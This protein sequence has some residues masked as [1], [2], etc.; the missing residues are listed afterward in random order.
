MKRLM[1]DDAHVPRY[2]TLVLGGGAALPPGPRPGYSHAQM[3]SPTSLPE[4]ARAGGRVLLA[5]LLALLCV[6]PSSFAREAKEG[7]VVVLLYPEARLL[8]EILAV[9]DAIRPTLDPAGAVHLYTEYLD[10]SRLSD[11]QYEGQVITFLREKYASRRIDL[12]MPVAFPTLRFFLKHRAE[13]FPGVPAVFCAANLDA[14]AGLELGSDITGVRLRSE[15]GATLEAALALQPATRR[16]VVITGTSEVDESLQAAAARDLARYRDRVEVTYL[17]GRPIARV[18]DEVAAL[19]KD[20]IVLF[21][22]M[23]RDQAGRLFTDREVVSLIARASSV[24]VY[25]WSETHLGHGIVGGRLA[26]FE[27]QGTLAAEL[28]VRVLRG[29]QAETLPV[30]DGGGT[31]YMFDERQLR[32]WGLSSSRLPPDSIVRYREASLWAL[33]GWNVVGAG[34]LV[35]ALA[36]LSTGLLI[37]RSGRRRAEL[38]LGERLRFETLLAELAATFSRAS[39]TEVDREIERALRRIADFL[40]VDWSSLREYSEDSQTARVTHGWMADGVDPLPVELGVSEVPWSASQL[41]R[42]EMIRFTRLEELPE[43]EAAVDRDTYRRLGIKSQVAIPLTVEGVVIGALTFSNVQAE[44]VWQDEFLHRLPL[45]GEVFANTLSRRRSEMEG[46]RLQQDLAHVGRVSTV[47]ELTAS[48][49]HE[50]NQPLTAILANAQ[51]ARRMLESDQA[52]LTELR[53]IVGDIVDDDERASEVIRRLRGF[54][55]K[56][57]LE[58]SSVDVGVLVGQVARLVAGDAILR[59]AEIQLELA[60]DVPP[61]YGDRVQLQQVVLNLILN[62]LDAMRDVEVGRRTLVLRTAREGPATVEV[63]VQDSGPGIDKG[64]LGRIFDAFY[65]TK[66]DGMGMGLAIV[67]S[68]VEAHG[69]RVG[70]RN[71]PE[72]G[73]TFWFTL[74]VVAQGP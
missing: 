38:S 36:L 41:Q 10:L 12:I 1:T 49:A 8:P 4:R 39:G 52:D 56:G 7:R 51:A 34:A 67:R 47:G 73:A 11:E 27:T 70:A 22:S 28:A 57:T 30:V 19:P 53:A 45:L 2:W 14:V 55:T 13:L 60:P 18:L 33:Y 62:G 48:L 43:R 40:T 16:A 31:A 65:T 26:S 3:L 50:L 15:W 68:I 58:R 72:G 17:T 20:A 54:L 64:A 63:T 69:G 6:A 44:R 74:P 23:L 46:Q 5:A 42:G 35:V 21:V 29:E 32:R 61:V 37:E 9:E 66:A 71:S 59:N 25:S 24:P